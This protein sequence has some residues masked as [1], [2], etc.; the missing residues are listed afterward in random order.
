VAKKPDVIQVPGT[1][2][3]FEIAD[4]Q[5]KVTGYIQ[6]L[7]VDIGDRVSAGQ[8]LAV[9][10]VPELQ[11]EL[12]QAQAQ[13]AQTGAALERAKASQA[14]AQETLTVAKRQ[15]APLE[16]IAR[17][18]EQTFMRVSALAKDQASSD[19]DLDDAAGA[20]DASA[21]EVETARARI[22]Q[23]QAEVT[24]AEA[25]VKLADSQ[26][27]AAKAQVQKVTTLI[28]YTR[29]VAPY[30]G[31]VSRRLVNRGALVQPSLAK[32]GDAIF[33]VQHLATVRVF[34]D[35][36]E[37]DVAKVRPGMPAIV[38]PYG[39]PG[40]TFRGQVTR[41]A[42]SIDVA[43]RTLRVEIDLPN[44]DFHLLHGMYAQVQLP[45][46]QPATMEARP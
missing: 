35:I 10:D 39:L 13:Q 37:A 14:A 7:N 28:G 29:I 2:E 40:Q 20:R 4:L 5:A 46:S 31:I 21:A 36:P 15:L 32:A 24:V 30:D 1:I 43:T 44:P 12:A 18:K 25:G 6:K 11:D 8:V 27:A 42:S 34:A 19:Q 33:T 22:G 26:I 41:T 3:A 17:L 9:I 45:L 23:A 16:A 38:T